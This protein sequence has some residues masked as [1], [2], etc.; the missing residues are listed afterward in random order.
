M[1]RHVSAP[2]LTL[3]AL[4]L[5]PSA[6]G[7]QVY[8][9][10]RDCGCIY[11]YQDT[12]AT[13]VS[14]VTLDIAEIG[15]LALD[16]QGHVL[17]SGHFTPSAYVA[18]LDPDTEDF[19][20]LF[21][22]T[23]IPSY[24]PIAIAPDEG[25]DIYVLMMWAGSAGSDRSDPTP[26]DFVALIADGADTAIVAYTFSAGLVVKDMKVRPQGTNEGNV[27][28]MVRDDEGGGHFFIELERTGENSLVYVQSIA[29]GGMMPSTP[30][31]FA[32]S[33]D[34]VIILV[35]ET[36]G[37]YYVDEDYGYVWSFGTAG[38]PGLGDMAIDPDGN[39]Y[40]ANMDTDRVRRYT[41]AGV[42]T[43][44]AFGSDLTSLQA[45]TVAGYTPTPV[46][47]LVLVEPWE[48]VE[49][50]FEGITQAGFTTAVVETTSSRVSPGAG[51]YLPSYAALPSNA[52]LPGP[53]AD[54]FTY[55]SLAT[56]AVYEDV[57]Q[58]D[59]L[60]EGSR[61]FFASGYGD[62][63]RDFTVVGSIE[64]ARGTIP[65]FTEFPAPMLERA[66]SDPTEVV[67]VEDTRALHEVTAYK[68]WRLELAMTYPDTVSPCP[69]GA[70][71]GLKEYVTT[72]RAYYDAEEYSSAIYDLAYMNSALR[73]YAGW[74]IPNSSASEAN[75]IVG[76]IL[77]HSKTLMFSIDLESWVGVEEAASAV[78][79]SIANPARGECVMALSG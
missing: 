28:V 58:V 60:L 35:D 19:D 75:N 46:G 39:I 67:L 2:I 20:L 68:F 47:D 23:Q 62:T 13:V 38:G 15:G 78:S 24:A 44:P 7:A 56:D 53:R 26:N 55:V 57:I 40:L 12:T 9:G 29:D 4:C 36:D 1:P 6:S 43:G 25:D 70:I 63:F 59:V 79:L 32:F 42:A 73:D 17:I 76:Q 31:A 14:P 61:L 5:L 71:H 74:C 52:G 10:D 22:M 16:H 3:A 72:A 11:S 37:L 34:G 49:V 65:R 66:D 33:P 50:T 77:G 27:V 48:N 69:W 8:A 51:N 64:D 21:P 54:V 30:T 41:S 18:R 45:I